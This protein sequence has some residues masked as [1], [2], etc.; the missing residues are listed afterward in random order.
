MPRSIVNEDSLALT[1][2][3][4][5][6]LEKSQLIATDT[7]GNLMSVG[8]GTTSAADTVVQRDSSKNITVDGVSTDT[9]GSSTGTLSVSTNL[10]LNGSLTW[11]SGHIQDMYD[12]AEVE[13]KI[14]H[15]DQESSTFTVVCVRSGRM[16]NVYFP[17]VIFSNITG[18]TVNEY[19][20][21]TVAIPSAFRPME[22][23]SYMD[24][25]HIGGASTTIRCRLLSTGLF[26]FQT[27]S[28]GTISLANFQTMIIPALSFAVVTG[29]S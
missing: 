1:I 6:D 29:S 24:A 16:C 12:V 9:I 11:S 8:Y 7:D 2:P 22:D 19:I 17:G 18:S 13:T 5:E 14:K 20:N 26:Q 27:E 15:G 4:F 21:T 23:V 3:S 25:C 28:Q 10:S